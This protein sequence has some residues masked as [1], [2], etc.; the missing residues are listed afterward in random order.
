MMSRT[1]A[2]TSPYVDTVCDWAPKIV[3]PFTN[4]V[5]LSEQQPQYYISCEKPL[6]YSVTFDRERFESLFAS[7]YHAYFWLR[8]TLSNITVPG[9]IW[10]LRQ[11][12]AHGQ[13]TFY[14]HL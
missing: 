1:D 8:G 6:N 3:L 2:Q 13:Y 14:K 5:Q 7:S 12:V 4:F 9:T 10:D 11:V